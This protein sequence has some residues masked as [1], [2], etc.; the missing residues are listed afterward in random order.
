[1]TFDYEVSER[2]YEIGHDEFRRRQANLARWRAAKWL[3]LAA[4]ALFAAA[5][6]LS[7]APDA[8]TSQG[9][10]VYSI[11]GAR[12]DITRLSRDID[13]VDELFVERGLLTKHK[14]HRLHSK[15]MVYVH[16]RRFQCGSVTTDSCYAPGGLVHVGEDLRGLAHEWA[17]LWDDFYGPH[18]GHEDARLFFAA[19]SIEI[20]ALRQIE[21]AREF[22]RA[23]GDGSPGPVAP[24]SPTEPI[25]AFFRGGDLWLL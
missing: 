3:L 10:D 9:I 18:R 24:W 19:G 22:A 8:R 7:C 4:L 17:H 20:E 11:D 16:A 1:M 25:A 6:M 12:I 23:G 5:V 2:K 14:L 13:I 15:A 21:S